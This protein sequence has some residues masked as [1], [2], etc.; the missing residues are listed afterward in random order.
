MRLAG[1]QVH[2]AALALYAG[3]ALTIL[4]SLNPS[5][6]V[7]GSDTSDVYTHLHL[8][9][10]H[11]DEVARGNPLPTETRALRFPDGGT[12]FPADL[13]G[14]LA[15]SPAVWLAGPVVAYNLLVLGDLV[16]ACAA[17]LRA[18]LRRDLTALA[19]QGITRFVVHTDLLMPS[20][21]LIR[22]C[23][24]LF[25]E[26]LDRDRQT[27]VYGVTLKGGRLSSGPAVR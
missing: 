23:D 9:S 27:R 17:P 12:L 10:W 2:L 14:S 1:Y 16:F 7:W 6:Q 21:R 18:R 4:G 11:A 13:I 20:S 25:G 26:P 5:R 15:V 3:V 22:T 8:L 24:A 19:R